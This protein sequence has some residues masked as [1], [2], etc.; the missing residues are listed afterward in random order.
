MSEMDSHARNLFR[1]GMVKTHLERLDPDLAVNIVLAG[2][3]LDSEHIFK[4]MQLMAHLQAMRNIADDVE[5]TDEQREEFKV[6][7][8]VLIPQ[9]YLDRN[10]EPQ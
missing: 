6:A 3:S 7:S 10:E 2:L 9:T 4:T 8:E 1:Q 5:A